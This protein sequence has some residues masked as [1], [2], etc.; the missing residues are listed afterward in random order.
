MKRGSKKGY[1][2]GF[3][4]I[5]T[6]FI[7]AVVIF[8][9]VYIATQIV[10]MKQLERES[11]RGK[12]IGVLLTPIETELEAEKFATILVPDETML[13]NG[14]DPPQSLG[15][16]FGSQHISTSIKSSIGGKWDVKNEQGVKSTFH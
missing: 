15:N 5:F 9:A 10:G 14:C 13:F 2:F 8:L 11:V 12:K 6:I 4:W 1:E 16:P 3:A 7:G